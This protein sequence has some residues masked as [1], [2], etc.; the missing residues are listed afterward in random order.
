MRETLASV[1][2]IVDLSPQETLDSAQAFLVQQG[3]HVAER[4]DTSLTVNRQKQESMFGYA[5]LNVIVE[6]TP[7]PSG[8][9]RIRVTGDDREG[10]MSE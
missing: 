3:Y 5:A 1:K 2:E 4:T 6:V 7:Q 9:V 10:V 8:G